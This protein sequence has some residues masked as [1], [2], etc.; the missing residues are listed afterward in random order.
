MTDTDSHPIAAK[1]HLRVKTRRQDGA[2]GVTLSERA[3]PKIP[4]A[5][6]D[7]AHRAQQN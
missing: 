3:G 7:I 5:P 4:K 2:D 6:L 1:K